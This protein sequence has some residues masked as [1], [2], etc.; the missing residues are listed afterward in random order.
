MRLLVHSGNWS[1]RTLHTARTTG[2]VT[3][4]RVRLPGTVRPL[5]FFAMLVLTK[6]AVGNY[7]TSKKFAPFVAITRGNARVHCSHVNGDIY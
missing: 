7:T 3:P 6:V 5:P 2:L 1:R 4:C